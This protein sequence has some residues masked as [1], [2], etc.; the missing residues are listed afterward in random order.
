MQT[1]QQRE[2]FEKLSKLRVGALFM[3]MGTGKT[4][5][6]L[7]L[8]S[9]K[10]HKVDYV[11]WIC[12]CALKGEIE[13]ERD[14]WYPDMELDI[15][16]CESI[17]GS[18]RIY[19]ETLE[20]VAGKTAFIVVDE[21]LKIKNRWAKR[22]QR[23]IEIG[24]QAKYKFILNG[25]PVSRNILDLWTQMEFLSPKILGMTFTE[26]KDTY[27][28]YYT[29]GKLKGRVRCHHNIP[30]LIAKINPYI[31]ECQ[32]EIDTKKT[33]LTRRY[34]LNSR[35]E[36]EIY[37]N[38]IFD[39][40]YDEDKDDLNFNAFTIKLQRYYLQH[41]DRAEQLQRLIDEIGER[42]IVFVRYL[43]GI[44]ADAHKITAAEKPQE[45][46]KITRDFKNGKF[47]VLYIT[48]GCG[49]YGL[50]LQFC[51]N[52]IFA[53]QVWDY[54]LQ[55][56]AEARVYRIGQADTVNYYHLHCDGVGLEDLMS[57]CVA[58]KSTLLYTIKKEINKT[59][60]GI[61]EWVKT[62]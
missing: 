23:I 42:V 34:D 32:L 49:A 53:E 47:K 18:D 27:C 17:G 1:D 11:L 35:E 13:A 26:F 2:A 14:K 46:L 12:P 41:S 20:K 30:H 62:I 6:A 25:T 56:Q 50:N 51:Q 44:P 54:A 31:F 7:D 40:Y 61:R 16:G 24:K 9:S 43:D 10:M 39:E 28:E 5:L 60:G 58:K 37:K 33:Y 55:V 36:Y 8:I 59:K 3:E 21:S 48:Y 45:R 19:L 15:V 38:E 22:T 29:R 57:D 4:R 52:V